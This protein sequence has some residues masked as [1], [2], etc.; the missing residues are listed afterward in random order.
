MPA[1]ELGPIDYDSTM[2]RGSDDVTW[3]LSFIGDAHAEGIRNLY[4]YLNGSGAKSVKACFHQNPKLDGVVEWAVITDSEK[5]DHVEIG[6]AEF[7]R[8]PVNL[9]TSLAG[10]P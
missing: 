10:D 8:V 6:Q 3:T 2:D 9:K 7:Y 1:I 4:Q 5:P